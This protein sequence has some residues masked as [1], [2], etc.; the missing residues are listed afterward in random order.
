MPSE[1]LSFVTRTLLPG[2]YSRSSVLKLSSTRERYSGSDGA[3][4][5]SHSYSS[6]AAPIAE[7]RTSAM[8]AGAL[9]TMSVL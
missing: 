5:R 2:I 9:K 7:F 4:S 6:D 8:L 3:S 1:N